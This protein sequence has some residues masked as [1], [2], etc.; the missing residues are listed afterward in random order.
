M[1]NLIPACILVTI[2][3]SCSNHSADTKAIMRSMNLSLKNS[4]ATLDADALKNYKTLENM[5]TE[6]KTA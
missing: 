3:Y 5:S 6:P 4:S 1:L 2:L